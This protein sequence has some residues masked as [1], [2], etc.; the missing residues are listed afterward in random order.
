L[1]TFKEP[2]TKLQKWRAKLNEYQFKIYI[3]GKENSVFDAY[4]R[5]KIKENHHSE[6]TQHS[7][8]EDNNNLIHLTEKPTNYFKKQIIFIESDKNKVK[9]STVFGNSITTIQYNVMII[10]YHLY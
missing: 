1:H 9:N 2:N 3:K 6:V 7:A 8:E 5:I 4:S 10:D